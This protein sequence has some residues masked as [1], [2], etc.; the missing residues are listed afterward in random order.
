V[1]GFR[2]NGLIFRRQKEVE[3]HILARW[4]AISF[5][6]RTPFHGFSSVVTLHTHYGHRT[7]SCCFVTMRIKLTVLENVSG[8]WNRHFDV[9]CDSKVISGYSRPKG[10]AGR[11]ILCSEINA[12]TELART[13]EKV[14]RYKIEHPPVWQAG[15]NL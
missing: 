1:A 9:S 2:G 3:R 5:S 14:E 13:Y 6:S 10:F 4:W 11:D 8:I 7:Y 12:S 15:L